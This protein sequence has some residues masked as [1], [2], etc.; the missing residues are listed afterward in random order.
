[1]SSSE[2]TPITK[3]RSNVL[4]TPPCGMASSSRDVVH[5][6]DVPAKQKG[7][8]LEWL[9]RATMEMQRRSAD[10]VIVAT[11]EEG[12]DGFLLYRFPNEDANATEVPNYTYQVFKNKKTTFKKP[13]AAGKAATKKPAA[14]ECVIGSEKEEI[15]EEIPP[16]A[17]VEGNEKENSPAN[18]KVIAPHMTKAKEKSYIQG[19]L[20][21]TSSKKLLCKLQSSQAS[22]TWRSYCQNLLRTYPNSTFEDMKF[23]LLQH[24]DKLITEFRKKDQ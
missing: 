14:S 22:T 17:S 2:P 3:A 9:D 13:A 6:S 8:D 24:R 19:K 10:G 23:S 5:I 15:P 1:M 4:L 12:P 11:M 20:E 16:V 21:K 18:E 7:H